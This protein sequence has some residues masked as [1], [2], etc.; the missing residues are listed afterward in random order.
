MSQ[1]YLSNCES[2][3]NDVLLDVQYLVANCHL[4]HV[5]P[6]HA[7]EY[8]DQEFE[9]LDIKV[10]PTANDNALLL[11]VGQTCPNIKYCTYCSKL[12]QIRA[13]LQAQQI[14]GSNGD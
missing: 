2:D 5:G 3:L 12:L 4:L 13:H 10:R 6:T 14:A 1:S 9:V 8:Q 11:V 7:V